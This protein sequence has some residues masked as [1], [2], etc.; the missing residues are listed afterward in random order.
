M[1]R[2]AAASNEPNACRAILA[3]RS[4]CNFADGYFL[5]DPSRDGSHTSRRQLTP[6]HLAQSPFGQLE[7]L[8][9]ET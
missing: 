4:V 7:E 6:C 5:P 9:G 2:H 3:V 1:Q 8:Q